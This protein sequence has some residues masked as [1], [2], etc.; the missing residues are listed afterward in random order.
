MLLTICDGKAPAHRHE[1]SSKQTE[2]AVV[3]CGCGHIF[4]HSGQRLESDLQ[5]CSL[6]INVEGNKRQVCSIHGYKSVTIYT[7]CF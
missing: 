6:A 4:Q 1:L 2:D 5:E 7:S 3:Q